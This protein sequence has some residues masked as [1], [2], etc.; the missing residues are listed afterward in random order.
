MSRQLEAR[1]TRLESKE[2]VLS[3]FHEMHIVSTWGWV[4]PTDA[5]PYLAEPLGTGALR[6]G[7]P[8]RYSRT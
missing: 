6:Q 5:E 3:S 8:I 4:L 7:R 2:W 1:I